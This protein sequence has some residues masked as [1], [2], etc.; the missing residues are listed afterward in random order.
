M[1]LGWGTIFPVQAYTFG[2]FAVSMALSLSNRF[3]RVHDE[4]D[5]LRLQLEEMVEDRAAELST[6]NERLRSEISERELAQEAMH[7]LERAVEQSIDGILVADLDG[8]TLFINEAWAQLHDREAFEVFGRRL[9]LFHSGEQMA[10]EVEPALDRVRQEGSWEGEIGHLRGDGSSF[11]T[12]TSVTLLR[13]PVGDPMG[14]VMVARDI[15]ARR[16]AMAEKQR[17]EARIQE[18]EKLRSL[19]DL[20]G[21]IAHDYNNLLTGVLGNSSLALHQLEPD[22]LARD[23][24]T[25]IGTAAERAAELTA[26]LLAYAGAETLVLERVDLDQL[27]SESRIELER[28]AGGGARLEIALDGS[29]PEIEIDA[30]QVRQALLNLVA[31][32]ADAVAA[33]GVVTLETGMVFADREYLE[34]SVLDAD[35]PPGDYVFVRFSDSRG[36][37]DEERRRRLFDPFA[38]TGSS[39]QGLGMAAVL[40]TARVHR[41]T[42]KVSS[43]TGG[44]S[45]IELLFPAA[46]ERVVELPST[47]PRLDQW[48]GSGTVL[49][50]DDE[51]IMREVS[52]SILEQW[53]FEVLATGEGHEALELYRQHMPTI[54]LVLLDRTMPTM[55]G[56]EVVKRILVLNPEARILLMS[57]Y[58]SDAVVDQLIDQGLADFLPKPFRPEELVEKVRSVLG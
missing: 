10:E 8:V 24:L 11:P 39:A 57:G 4:L 18:A 19:A 12:W 56:E 38:S 20:A 45:T 43:R 58:K 36:E 40:G 44:G 47:A 49:V 7:M 21:G 22:S 34:S 50:V 54:R 37:I 26:Q 5:G 51:Y 31:N 33:G 41:G 3:S 48:R 2:L 25:Q 6:A 32:A 23:K 55:P 16:R 9:D 17:I 35:H 52:R 27:I 42:I 15:T 29:L 28:G 13:D 30:T 46:G 53:G 1:T 14:F